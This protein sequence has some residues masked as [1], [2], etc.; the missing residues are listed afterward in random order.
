MIENTW[1]EYLPGLHKDKK[2]N[3]VRRPTTDMLLIV[4]CSMLQMTSAKSD[5]EHG[6]QLEGSLCEPD[7]PRICLLTAHFDN[8]HHLE[9]EFECALTAAVLVQLRSCSAT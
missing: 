5:L 7:R 4:A 2:T 3:N 9:I 8:N 6:R 1:K